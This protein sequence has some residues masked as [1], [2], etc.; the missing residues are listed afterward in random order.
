MLALAVAA[1]AL[2][3]E[4]RDGLGHP[5]AFLALAVACLAGLAALGSPSRSVST[6][7]I[8]GLVVAGFGAAPFLTRLASQTATDAGVSTPAW[9]AASLGA[10]ALATAAAG[11]GRLDPRAALASALIACGLAGAWIITR[12]PTPH[13]D[14]WWSQNAGI[15]AFLSGGNPYT[16]TFPDLYDDPNGYALGIV[17]DGRVRLGYP[18][19]PVTL[20]LDAPFRA[21]FGDIR[22]GHLV[23]VLATGVLIAGRR[24]NARSTVC[25]GL[26]LLLPRQTFV[27]ESAWMDPWVALLGVAT[28]RALERPGPLRGVAA[29]LF[30][31]S[32]PSMI[33][34]VAAF[35][36]AGLPPRT[37]VATAGVA[38][39][40]ALIVVLPFR[41]ADPAAFD[42]STWRVVAAMPT[43]PLSL[44]FPAP[45]LATTG[46][47]AGAAVG[48]LLAPLMA[49]W[50]LRG[51]ARGPQVVATTLSVALLHFFAWNKFAWCNYYATV[52][53]LLA[54][55]LALAPDPDT[56][57]APKK[58]TGRSA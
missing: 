56:L 34:V 43:H 16:S 18:Y 32:K 7:G 49:A 52:I 6:P 55:A 22:W 25:A 57:A 10:A 20:L 58:E 28:L 41:A 27:I 21:L 45:L 12:V 30:V 4:I 26:Y 48:F 53:A 42:H 54:T 33:P 51:S 24:P 47:D 19:P 14:V 44:S 46:L 5:A 3:V 35:L 40:S 38:I 1:L 11:F 37:L 2:A 9:V 15:D 17:R 39:F 13:I 8:L 29:G 23:A 36:A 50:V 31:A